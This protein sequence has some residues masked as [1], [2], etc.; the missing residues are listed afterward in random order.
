MEALL[1]F[2]ALSADAIEKG[3]IQ[4]RLYQDEEETGQQGFMSMLSHLLGSPSE[5]ESKFLEVCAAC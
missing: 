2:R 4:G 3:L 1:R 5:C